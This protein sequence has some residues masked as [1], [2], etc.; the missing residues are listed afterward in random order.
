MILFTLLFALLAPLF[1]LAGTPGALRALSGKDY[2]H[3]LKRTDEPF[4]ARLSYAKRGPGSVPPTLK[5]PAAEPVLVVRLVH[6]VEIHAV[7]MEESAVEMDVVMPEVHAKRSTGLQPVARQVN[8]V[9]P[10]GE[11]CG[12]DSAGNA[13]CN[14]HSASETQGIAADPTPG[15]TSILGPSD[16][17]S[18]SSATTGFTRATS[19]TSAA[20]STGSHTT[21]TGPN[22]TSS[23]SSGGALGLVPS[24]DTFGVIGTIAFA[25]AAFV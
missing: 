19:T 24:R 13:T 11:T 8:N 6:A 14:G 20:T 9:T 23:G 10:P 5:V 12:R 15:N 16:T 18:T 2:S 3:H 22:T 4:P 17:T 25:L 21:T 1:V 7:R